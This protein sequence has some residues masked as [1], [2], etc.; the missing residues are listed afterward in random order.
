MARTHHR[1]SD[2]MPEPPQSLAAL[3][4][5]IDR[6]E[7]V[8]IP[9][10]TRFRGIETRQAA[11]L[12]GPE[13]WAEFSP[14]L[15]YP[16][17]EAASWLNAALEAATQPYPVP[18]RT[19]VPINATIPVVDPEEAHRIARSFGARTAKVKVADACSTHEGDLARI[20]AVRDAL[21]PHAHIRIDANMAWSKEE[22]IR[23]IRDLDHEAEGLEYAEQPCPT[24]EDLAYVRRHVAVPIAADES[25]RRADDPL[26]VARAKAADLLVMKVQP[27]G[28]IRTALRLV[29]EAGLPVVVSSALETSV[30]ISAGLAFAAALDSLPYACGLGTARLLTADVAASPLISADGTLPVG[31]IKVD[32]SL[33]DEHRASAEI[34]QHWY[35]RLE[36]CARQLARA[37]HMASGRQD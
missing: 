3:L 19:C 14:F 17:P 1:Y 25:V 26:A 32:E 31:R 13:G 5:A 33:L 27:L 15:E 6:I 2:S 9:L 16:T 12:H 21:G 35:A 37:R 7:V 23:K 10:S 20:A 24:V 11:L 34:H 29:E 8:H 36:A 30:G 4:P 28:G 22:A 18:Q